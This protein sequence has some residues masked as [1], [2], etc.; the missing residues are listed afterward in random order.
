MVFSRF[1]PL[2]D[3]L[4]TTRDHAS[5]LLR[6]CREQRERDA[7]IL[8]SLPLLGRGGD[9]TPSRGC[10]FVGSPSRSAYDGRHREMNKHRRPSLFHLAHRLDN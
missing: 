1:V 3:M 9:L 2:A 4:Y 6:Q 7:R 5:S 8:S 10:S